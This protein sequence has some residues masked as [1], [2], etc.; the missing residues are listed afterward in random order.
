MGETAPGTGVPSTTSKHQGFQSLAV[1][2]MQKSVIGIP[3]QVQYPHKAGDT[4]VVR[5]TTQPN[6]DQSHPQKSE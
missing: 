1:K 3:I 6:Q 2:E 4:K 5:A